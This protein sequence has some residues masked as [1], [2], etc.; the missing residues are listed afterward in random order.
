VRIALG[1]AVVGVLVTLL[2]L[3]IAS[4]LTE[5]TATPRPTTS[6][7]GAWLSPAPSDATAAPTDIAAPTNTAPPSAP[8]RGAA[9]RSQAAP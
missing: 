4:E 3:R 2:A 1:G 7:R 8:A 9:R 5:T 6:P